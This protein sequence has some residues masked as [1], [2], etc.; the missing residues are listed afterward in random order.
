MT[1]KRTHRDSS[2]FSMIELVTT[3][4]LT[5][6]LTVG[7][8]N[9]LRHPMQGYV[10]VSRRAELVALADISMRRM[11]RDLR[12]ALPN[13]VRVA[14]G[15]TVL[16]LLHTSGGARYRLEPGVN[17]AGGPDEEDHTNASDWL[18]FGGDTSWNTLGRFE[19]L[20][21]S[22]GTPLPA[23]TRV[24]IYPT[25]D[26]V[27]S[28]AASGS[29]PSSITPS[30]TTLTVVDDNDEEQLQL[31]SSHRFELESPSSRLYVVDTPVTY[32][33]DLAGEALWRVDGYTIA[34]AQPTSLAAAP[35]SAGNAAR[36]A[37]RVERCAFDYVA[38]TPTR[39]GLITIEIVLVSAEERVRLLQQVQVHNAP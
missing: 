35:L 38:G 28:E 5:G 29:N 33:C 31:S 21:F 2:G 24:A 16:E 34:S 39:A 19:N 27:W 11:S 7:L 8:T 37:D 23:G 30:G 12:R 15:G 26:S 1:G 4:A 13:S 36:A 17:D 20:A 22:Y 6:I 25:G 14:G 9:L 10:A 18:S 3:I 32:L